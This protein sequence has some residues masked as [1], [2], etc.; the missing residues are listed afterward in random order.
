[1]DYCIREPTVQLVAEIGADFS[2]V[3]RYALLMWVH[4]NRHDGDY[5]AVDELGR[6]GEKGR[7][8]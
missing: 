3:L 5:G 4:P 2:L 7:I 1:M 6:L 8:R